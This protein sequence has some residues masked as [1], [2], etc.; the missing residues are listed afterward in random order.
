MTFAQ[1][2]D[3]IAGITDARLLALAGSFAEQYEADS[4]APLRL[5]E[6]I[7]HATLGGGKRFR[8]FLVIE[9]AALF[10]LSADKA[11]DTAVALECVHSYSLVH[12][13]L[14]AM[15]ND[16]M[17]RGLPTVWAKYDEWTAILAGD[18]LLTLAFEILSGADTHPDPGTRLALITGLARAAGVAGMVG[19]QAL[20]LAAERLGGGTGFTAERIRHMQSLKTGALIRFACEAGGLLG[21]AATK[22]QSALS[23]FG[24]NIGFAFQI[25]DDL[26]D[27]EG[28]AV[29]VGKA[30][31]KDAAMGKATYVSLLGLDA[32]RSE[33]RRAEQAAIDALAIFGGRAEPLI[34]AARFVANRKS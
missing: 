6:A 34:E 17:R 31:A 13:D 29:T 15:D 9:S 21:G 28:D 23:D 7:R 4:V 3:R 14:P 5:F 32:A 27:A 26:L 24:R 19:G 20:D 8:P 16:R 12:D 30:V 33:L 10:G 18:A 22:E 1:S 11:L 2:L 25:A